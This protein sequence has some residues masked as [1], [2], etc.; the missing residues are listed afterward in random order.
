[1]YGLLAKEIQD[2]GKQI[3]ASFGALDKR[4][5]EEQESRVNVKGEVIA[6]WQARNRYNSD[7]C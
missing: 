3:E 7:V 5:R 4:I 2:I 1:M 6:E